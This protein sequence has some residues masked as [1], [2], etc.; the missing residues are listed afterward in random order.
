MSSF[1]IQTNGVNDIYLPDGRNLIM[2]SGLP[3]CVQNVQQACLMRLAEDVYN[4]STGVDYFGTIF[5]PQQN[6]SAARQSIINAILSVGDVI[7]IDSLT[8]ATIG[9]T[10]NFVANIR[11]TFGPAT[12]SLPT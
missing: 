12:V 4:Q 11:T 5:T 10:F 6:Y 3:A 7:S 2:L 9:N 8:I 1:T